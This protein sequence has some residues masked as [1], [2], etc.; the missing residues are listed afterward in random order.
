MNDD[1]IV[2]LFAFMINEVEKIDKRMK[3]I[4]MRKEKK[5][6]HVGIN[7]RSYFRF[8]RQKTEEGNTVLDLE[9]WGKNFEEFF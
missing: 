8:G 2:N 4:K 3:S 6:P 7:K 9:T 1:N 5:P